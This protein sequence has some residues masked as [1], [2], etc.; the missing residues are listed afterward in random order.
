VL[1]SKT[2]NELTEFI[3][4]DGIESAPQPKH[5]SSQAVSSSSQV[6]S[7]SNV[8]PVVV[9]S[10]ESVNTNE[11]APAIATSSTEAQ[12]AEAE[13]A[14]SSDHTPTG[15]FVFVPR[16]AEPVP[17]PSPDSAELVPEPSCFTESPPVSADPVNLEVVA[18]A[19]HTT[20][21]DLAIAK[22]AQDRALAS[23]FLQD[24]PNQMTV[25]GLMLLHENLREGAV[26]ALFHNN[27]F[28]CAWKCNG[29]I[30]ELITDV[31]IVDEQPLL[32]WTKLAQTDN[33]SMFLDAFLRR[34]LSNATA[35]AQEF[36]L[37]RR[38][39]LVDR[40][41]ANPAGS[42]NF[43]WAHVYSP[44][45]TRAEH[46]RIAA[47]QSKNTNFRS[48]PLA[49]LQPVG[50]ID[51]QAKSATNNASQ[52]ARIQS[53]YQEQQRVMAMRHFEQQEYEREAARR[54]EAEKEDDGC[55]IS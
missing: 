19:S 45:Y 47:Q 5:V 4:N 38:S 20:D 54:R 23:K 16:P 31:R 33:D 18:T 34:P 15:R 44:A 2:Y 10:S 46:E 51:S 22:S 36:N 1:G 52:D 42:D 55:L 13:T 29:E 35:A 12:H 39:A 49:A 6:G 32:V 30:Y 21:T 48:G 7:D 40:H 17:A 11:S 25:Y 37:Q 50:P 9:Q 53:M 26:A 43:Y 14:P 24:S 28:S 3:L 27:H 8:A 41:R